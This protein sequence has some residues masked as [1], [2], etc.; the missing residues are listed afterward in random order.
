MSPISAVL[1][2]G[3]QEV[4]RCLN[5]ILKQKWLRMIKPP[6]Y[7]LSWLSYRPKRSRFTWMRNTS[8][9]RYAVPHFARSLIRAAF[10]RFRYK[11][12]ASR[13]NTLLSALATRPHTHAGARGRRD[14]DRR[15]DIFRLTTYQLRTLSMR[16]L[17]A[18]SFSYQPIS[19]ISCD[20]LAL[21]CRC[22]SRMLSIAASCYAEARHCR[23]ASQYGMPTCKM[24]L[25]FLI[26]YIYDEIDFRSGD[27]CAPFLPYI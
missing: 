11:A 2:S 13:A 27:R 4:G 24:T 10:S 8:C 19:R 5:R 3:I 16:E 26:R 18:F 6:H 1:A 7:F 14:D 12:S 9:S 15:F 25:M 20:E 23:A 22:D 21:S 17:F